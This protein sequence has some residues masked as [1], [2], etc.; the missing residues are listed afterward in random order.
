MMLLKPTLDNS[1]DT[2]WAASEDLMPNGDYGTPRA[3]NYSTG[4]CTADGDVNQDGSLNVLDI[5]LTTNYILGV[6]E[7]TEEQICIGDRNQD[8]IINV[9]DIVQTVS[10]ILNP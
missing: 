5:V 10:D 7:F 8:N 3:A 1:Q 4:E 2:N 9:L 6:T